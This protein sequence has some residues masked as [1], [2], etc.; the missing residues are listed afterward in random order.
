MGREGARDGGMLRQRD[1]G[2]GHMWHLSKLE[3]KSGSLLGLRAMSLVYSPPWLPDSF[4]AEAQHC[5]P[6]LTSSPDSPLPA[7]KT[8]V[9]DRYST[10]IASN[11][12]F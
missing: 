10:S 4:M 3:E 5:I 7:Y 6:L 8:L 11:I 2:Q 1:W 9:G 12:G